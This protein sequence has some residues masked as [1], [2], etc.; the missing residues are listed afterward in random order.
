MNVV[1]L[2]SRMVPRRFLTVRVRSTAVI[3]SLL[4]GL[5][6]AA[7]GCVHTPLVA[8][9]GTVI[10]LFPTSNV[11]PANGSTDIVALLIENGSVPP[12]AGNTG[13]ALASTGTPVHNG[14]VVS[15]TTTLGRM[16][17]SE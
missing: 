15:F 11:L 6:L 13:T 14:T 1:S 5:F 10:T 8:P 7:N 9:S 16:E 17:P 12:T 4:F 2:M 3:S